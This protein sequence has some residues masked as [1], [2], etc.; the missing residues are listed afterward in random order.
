MEIDPTASAAHER[1]GAVLALS[2][3]QSCLAMA[4][5][6]LIAT[7]PDQMR[8]RQVFDQLLFQTLTQPATLAAPDVAILLKDMA[9]TLFEPPASLD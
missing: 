1:L 5:R 4:V 3:H 8:M 2:A 9:K 6:A 7:H